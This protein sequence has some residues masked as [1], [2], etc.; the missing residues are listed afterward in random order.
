M[1][2]LLILTTFLFS[3]C[4]IGS[5]RADS[6]LTTSP[7]IPAAEGDV[8]F[9]PVKNDN[10]GIDLRVKHLA[11][12]EKLTPPAQTYVA[13]I[14]NGKDAAPQNIGALTVDKELTGELSTVTPLHAFDLFVTAEASG[15]VQQP[16]GQPLLWTSYSR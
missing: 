12:P 4:A 15:Q 3:A 8:K 14:R 9:S 1:K 7:L 11:E 16:A 5:S 2:T 6:H 13:W 10:T